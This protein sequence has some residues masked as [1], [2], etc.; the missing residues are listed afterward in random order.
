MSWLSWCCESCFPFSTVTLVCRRGC[1]A[2]LYNVLLSEARLGC[3][4]IVLCQ[5]IFTRMSQSHRIRNVLCTGVS[6]VDY[7][8]LFLPVL[9]L[10]MPPR[11]TVLCS[12]LPPRSCTGT[13]STV[14]Q[15]IVGITV[16]T[17]LDIC[18]IVSLLK[19]T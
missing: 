18:V 2:D 3:M 5:T 10:V 12:V 15:E 13:V 4:R 9:N 7:I 11:S 1:T 17:V 14:V 8:L 6:H 16:C 19:Q